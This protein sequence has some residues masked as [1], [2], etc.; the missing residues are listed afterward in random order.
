MYINKFRVFN[1]FI[2]IIMH[3]TNRSQRCIKIE[4]DN[5]SCLLQELS[6]CFV[7]LIIHN[8]FTL[9]IHSNSGNPA[10]FLLD[11]PYF[12]KRQI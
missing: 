8:I 6:S 10:Q 2:I 5:S 1:I 4:A 12:K 9:L 7:I 3:K 11:G